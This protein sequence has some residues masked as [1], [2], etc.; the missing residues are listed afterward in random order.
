[1]QQKS[2]DLRKSGTGRRR[3]DERILQHGEAMSRLGIPVR[4]GQCVASWLFSSSCEW[5]QC[6]Y[7]RPGDSLVVDRGAT[8]DMVTS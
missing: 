6:D 3:S 5:L 7:A 1:M 8:A 2:S 4:D